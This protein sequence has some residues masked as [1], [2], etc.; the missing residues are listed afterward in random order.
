MSAAL[1]ALIVCLTVLIVVRSA[2]PLAARMVAVAER[3]VERS[4]A[5]AAPAPMPLD[6]EMLV[7]KESEGWAREQTKM[8][9]LEL[10]AE[11][12][13]DWTQVQNVVAQGGLG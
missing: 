8:R 4:P 6:L 3:R 10:Y 12:G 9:L 2:L 5:L 1:V 11:S 7:H 13:G